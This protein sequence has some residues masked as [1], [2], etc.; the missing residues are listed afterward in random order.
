MTEGNSSV[1]YF[2]AAGGGSRLLLLLDVQAA[3]LHIQQQKTS[4]E[5]PQLVRSPEEL[6]KEIKKDKVRSCPQVKK[7]LRP[8]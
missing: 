1:A 7:N 8:C 2:F 3:G 5:P 6:R 4:C